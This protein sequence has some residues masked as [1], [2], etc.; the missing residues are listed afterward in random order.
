VLHD[1]PYVDKAPREVYASLLSSGIYHCS[2]STMY[3]LLRKTDDRRNQLNPRTYARPEL[4]ATRPN[5]VWSWD[6]TK[7]KAEDKWC[8][9]YLYVIMDIYS[10]YVVG[11]C[12]AY[13]ED[14]EIAKELILDACLKNNI[15]PGQLTIHADRG[16]SMT[17]KLVSQ[18]LID[19]DVSKTHSRPHVSNDNCYSEAQFKTL[20]YRPDFPDRFANLQI[21]KEFCVEFFDWY[22]VEHHHSGIAMLTPETM[23]Y[24]KADE[25]IA[26]R[27]AVLDLQYAARPERFVNKAPKHPTLPKAVYINQP[28]EVSKEQPASV[29]NAQ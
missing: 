13:K 17:S 3:R 26:K 20:K 23:H 6:I 14:S 25:V 21:A 18:L 16:S 24:G 12:I 19:L 27:Q 7:L 10:R 11:W 22:N 28:T 9:Y 5:Q 15:K 2:V 4:L 1:K 8:Y 29:P